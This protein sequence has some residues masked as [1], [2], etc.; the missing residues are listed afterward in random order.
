MVLLN[1]SKISKSY[2]ET[3]ILSDISFNVTDNDKIGILGVNGAGKSTLFKILTEEISP[4]GG[5]VYKAKQLKIACMEQHM[6]AFSERSAYNEVLT[7]FE[8]LEKA[9]EE[10]AALQKEL[11]TNHDEALINRF[12][13]INQKFIDNGG[14]TYKS[15]INSTLTGLGITDEQKN[16]PLSKLSGGQRTRVML[17]KLLLEDADI[18]LLDEPTNHLDIDAVTWLEDFLSS[19]KGAIMVVTHDRYFLD[20]VT[21]KIFEIE[22]HKLKE[23]NGNY[24]YYLTKKEA[25]RVAAEKDYDLKAK[26]IKRLEGIIKQQKQWNRERNFQLS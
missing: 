15:R 22:N 5:E 9:E 17:A 19:Y 3:V 2:G 6:E 23:Y 21:N 4:D 14:L 26:E 16:M 24:S 18:L 20:K 12:H 13:N 10:I 11:E 7:V 8:D 25:D 1:T